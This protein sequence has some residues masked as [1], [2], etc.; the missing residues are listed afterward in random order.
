MCV[1]CGHNDVYV[2][3]V[4]MVTRDDQF[5]MN[6]RRFIVWILCV[7]VTAGGSLGE[8]DGCPEVDQTGWCPLSPSAQQQVLT[9]MEQHLA[10]VEHILQTARISLD[11]SFG[12]RARTQQAY[13]REGIYI[14]YT[15][16]QWQKVLRQHEQDGAVELAIGLLVVVNVGIVI[17]WWHTLPPLFKW[18]FSGLRRALQWHASVL[19]QERAQRT[20]ATCVPLLDAMSEATQMQQPVVVFLVAQ[21]AFGNNDSER[22]HITHVMNGIAISASCPMCTVYRSTIDSWELPRMRRFLSW[23]VYAALIGGIVAYT[24]YTRTL[25]VNNLV[26]VCLSHDD[27][28]TKFHMCNWALWRPSSTVA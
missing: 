13:E 8:S 25:F 4:W 1:T 7:L 18:L 27:Q 16:A 9:L 15:Q 6:S 28:G 26:K 23:F 3:C 17:I 5:A 21:Y 11:N 2:I 19:R 14:G 22:A 24:C 20:V 10:E 12:S